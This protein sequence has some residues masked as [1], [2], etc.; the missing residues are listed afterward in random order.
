MGDRGLATIPEHGEEE[1]EERSFIKLRDGLVALLQN[2][3]GSEQ[4]NK[5]LDSLK[6]IKVL[7]SGNIQTS[8]NLASSGEAN[9][10]YLMVSPPS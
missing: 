8:E 6:K 9:P 1:L 5:S 4:R 3:M 10:N 7:K 2:I